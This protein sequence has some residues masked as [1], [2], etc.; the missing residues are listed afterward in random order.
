MTL[1]T[2]LGAFVIGALLVSG[3]LGSLT[4][5]SVVGVV[6]CLLFAVGAGSVA[7]VGAEQRRLR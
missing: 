2:F 5:L 1:G 4:S 7:I 3:V 6:I